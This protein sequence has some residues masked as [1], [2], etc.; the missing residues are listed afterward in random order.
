MI[1]KTH[2]QHSRPPPAQSCL[3]RLPEHS[4]AS[5]CSGA[6]RLQWGGQHQAAAPK[7]GAVSLAALHMACTQSISPAGQPGGRPPVRN[8]TW[9]MLEPPAL[10]LSRA[11]AAEPRPQV[12]AT[13]P[14]SAGQGLPL[15]H[16][17]HITHTALANVPPR[18]SGKHIQSEAAVVLALPAPLRLLPCPVTAREPTGSHSSP[19]SQGPVSHAAQP[20]M[21]GKKAPGRQPPTA[22][23][24]TVKTQAAPLARL[25]CHL[26]ANMRLASH[27]GGAEVV[28]YGGTSPH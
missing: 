13:P 10:P 22:T 12:R 8:T 20:N 5:D 1:L 4:N 9:I 15:C 27:R 11:L 26:L 21:P 16:K 24:L 25:R 14:T 19:S 28:H 3:P 17:A 2:C 6:A 23:T 18:T 7:T